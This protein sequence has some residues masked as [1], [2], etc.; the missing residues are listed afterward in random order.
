ML[1]LPTLISKPKI[2]RPDAVRL[3]HLVKE[4]GEDL[5]CWDNGEFKCKSCNTKL[6]S[7]KNFYVTSYFKTSKHK[8]NVI[9]LSLTLDYCFVRVSTNIPI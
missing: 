7:I 8:C 2:K 3:R 1:M 4:F 5:L 6:S 9:V